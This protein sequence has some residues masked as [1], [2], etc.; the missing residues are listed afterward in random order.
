[1][2]NPIVSF[3]LLGELQT[4]SKNP[5]IIE[6]GH[7]YEAQATNGKNYSACPIDMKGLFSPISDIQG[8]DSFQALTL[9]VRFVE[10]QLSYFIRKGGLLYCED[11]SPF[12]PDPYFRKLEKP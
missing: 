3:R 7:P 11:G 2:K 8:E 10:Q 9:A 1:M 4:G 6:I 5:I 12:D